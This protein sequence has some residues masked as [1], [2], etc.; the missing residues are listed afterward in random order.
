[1]TNDTQEMRDDLAAFGT[2][3]MKDGKHIPL[4]NVLIPSKYFFDPLNCPGHYWR[5]IGKPA[6]F[7]PGRTNL[8]PVYR[9]AR[10]QRCGE[11][12]DE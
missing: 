7:I 8:E 11:T 9:R 5:G 4:K 3:A 2:A 10:C 6:Y 1:M 12:H